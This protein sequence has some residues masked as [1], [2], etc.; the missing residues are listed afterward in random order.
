MGQFRQLVFTASTGVAFVALCI[1]GIASCATAQDFNRNEMNLL[2]G[3]TSRKTQ[4]SLKSN[5]QLIAGQQLRDLLD[6]I[7]KQ[8]GLSFWIDR[9]IDP[10]QVPE[11]PPGQPDSD[12]ADELRR[13]AIA[14]G[15]AGG[16]VENIYLIAPSDRLSR[17]QRAS[18]VLHGQLASAKRDQALQTRRLEWPDICSS[19]EVLQTIG[20]VWDWDIPTTSL[21]HDLYHA[22]KL[23]ESHFATQ[24]SLLLGGFDMQASLV[25][26]P[27]GASQFQIGPLS[28]E[29]AWS[30][31]YHYGLSAA[32][33]Q[34]LLSKYPTARLDDVDGKQT[35]LKGETN[36]H[37]DFLASVAF[38]PI[39][40][41]KTEKQQRYTFSLA[42]EVPVYAVLE[43]LGK[44]LNFKVEW[45][46]KCSS[47][48]RNK[49]I[50]F[51][52][53]QVTRADLLQTIGEAAG[54]RCIDLEHT[55]NI[56]PK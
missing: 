23:P 13:L 50:K 31:N 18:V 22:G 48:Q 45:S 27:S 3:P 16:L 51:S 47:M 38:Q 53:Q 56:L 42:G 24:I 49:L 15:G 46:E 39:V 41:P 21:P 7:S 17:I 36:L 8:Y 9:R 20:Q 40:R 10:N 12:L 11:L 33:R 26:Q 28:A 29:V 6:Q 25:R 37:L 35:K 4:R 32:S 14:C 44:K 30:D 52:V 55:V 19:N 1:F 2:L 34:L 5:C 43:E 54:L